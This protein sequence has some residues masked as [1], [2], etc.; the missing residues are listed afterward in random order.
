MGERAELWL[1][2]LVLFLAF[3]S[4]AKCQNVYNLLVHMCILICV[5]KIYLICISRAYCYG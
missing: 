3:A 2:L 5:L 1:N 4:L